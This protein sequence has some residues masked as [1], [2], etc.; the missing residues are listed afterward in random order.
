LNRDRYRAEFGLYVGGALMQ[1]GISG[2]PEPPREPGNSSSF[3]LDHPASREIM[4]LSTNA[5]YVGA[6]RALAAMARELGQDPAE[7]EAAAGRIARA[8]NETMWIENSGLYGY[9]LHPSGELDTHQEAAGLALAITFGVA[10]K[11][12]ADLV[13]SQTYRAPYG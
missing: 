8:I 4:C 6:H 3:V 1:D 7:F 11:R 10:D 9:F 12:Q 5:V 2:Y 13:L